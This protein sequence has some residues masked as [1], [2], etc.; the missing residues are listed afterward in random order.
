MESLKIIS[1]NVNGMNS[2][3]KRKHIFH[4]LGKQRPNIVALQETHINH[5]DTKYMINKKLGEEFLSQI[6]KKK[7]EVRLYILKRNSNLKKH[8]Q[9]N[10]E[11]ILR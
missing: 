1:L 6:E 9:I 3:N 11:D 10:K 4:W 5:K 8:L 7:K 2:A